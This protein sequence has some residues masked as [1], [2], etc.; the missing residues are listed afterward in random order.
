MATLNFL[1]GNSGKLA[2][3]QTLFG[4]LG[5]E[6]QAFEVDG[7]VPDVI[8]P[9]SDNL[10]TV[11]LA[12]IAQAVELLASQNRLEESLLVEDSGLF[13]DALPEFPG[14]YSAHVLQSI[15]C[16]G[17]LRLLDNQRTAYFLTVAALWTGEAVEVFI[18]RCDGTISTEI[19]GEGGFGY[20][21]IFIPDESEDGRTFAEMTHE[22]KSAYSH[23]GRALRAL[24][25]Y[26]D[27]DGA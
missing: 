14:V 3:A 12:K 25:D 4:P 20:D 21:P 19:K 5:W 26:L 7:E 6:I 13:I 11:A 17:I 9:Q 10:T 15:G 24:F 16:D 8:E 1:T 2:E 23:R 18:G 27:E 22:E